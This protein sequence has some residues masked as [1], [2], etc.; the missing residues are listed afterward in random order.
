MGVGVEVGIGVGAGVPVGVGVEVGELHIEE[1]EQE[2][3]EPAIQHTSVE[4]QRLGPQE[5]PQTVPQG[6]GVG[7]SETQ[8]S[9]IGSHT[10]PGLQNFAT[11]QQSW[12]RPPHAGLMVEMKGTLT[13][14]LNIPTSTNAKKA[15]ISPTI[16]YVI[17]SLA[18]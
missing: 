5:P 9:E 18:P 8:K 16:E 1:V 7:V 2:K 11:P 4:R 17:F 3:A 12:L 13:K 10:N 15:I 14:L 6:A